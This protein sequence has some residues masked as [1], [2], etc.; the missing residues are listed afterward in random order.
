MEHHERFITGVRNSRIYYQCWLPAG[1]ARAALIVVHGLA[2]HGGRYRHL[3]DRFVPQGYAVYAIDHQGHGKSDGLRVFVRQFQD[4]TGTLRIFTDM[5]A[6]WQAGKPM[7]MVGHSMGGL[8]GA[9][10]LIEDQ[11]PLTGAVLSGPLVKTYDNASPILVFTVKTLSTLMPRL[12]LVGLKARHVSRDPVVVRAYVNDPLVHTGKTTARL[13][14]ELVKTMQLVADGASRITLP[15]LIVQGGAD[16]LVN[17]E[18]SRM[19]YERASSIDKTIKTYDGLYH[20][21]FNEPER[22]MVLGDVRS[23]METRIDA[24]KQNHRG[25][26]ISE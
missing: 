9:A 15:L 25:Q 17:P 22:D 3:V 14:A 16:K 2:E 7:F 12:P 6:K 19:L 11:H 1:E 23:W 10:Y 20:E 24:G 26:P 4:Y 18:G 21:V 13:A 5:V 8:I